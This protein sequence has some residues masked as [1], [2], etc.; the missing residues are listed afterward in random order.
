MPLQM[1]I[2]LN[3]ILSRRRLT[4]SMVQRM[5]AFPFSNI[6]YKYNVY[7]DVSLCFAIT[8]NAASCLTKDEQPTCL[9]LII[10]IPL[11][12]YLLKVLSFIFIPL[13]F[14]MFIALLFLPLMRILGRR[15]VPKV[16]SIVIVLLLV[17]GGLKNRH[18]TYSI[19]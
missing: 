10:V 3:Q 18:R 12:F 13:I 16:I 11:V 14:S 4:L 8:K 9:L 19:V 6:L 5:M 1:M 2:H 15:R 17:I 7:F